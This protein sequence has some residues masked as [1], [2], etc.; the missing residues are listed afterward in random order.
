M[1]QLQR[2][3]TLARQLS[4]TVKKEEENAAGLRRD[5][6]TLKQRVVTAFRRP[7]QVPDKEIVQ[8]IGMI[9]GNLRTFVVQ[10]LD[11]F[12]RTNNAH[13]GNSSASTHGF[14][15]TF[16]NTISDLSNLPESTKEWTNTYVSLSANTNAIQPACIRPYVFVSIICKTLCEGFKAH[17]YFG[18]SAA[19]PVRGATYMAQALRPERERDTKQWFDVMWQLIDKQN[20][21][22]LPQAE[23]ALLREMVESVKH[24]FGLA[25]SIVW[26][27][28]MEEKL[29]MIFKA[30]LDLF[31]ILHRQDARYFVDMAPAN[32]W[33][34]SAAQMEEVLDVEEGPA[35]L[36]R[37][38]IDISVFPAVYKRDGKREED[39]LVTIVVKGR[40]V[41]KK[42][43][44]ANMIELDTVPRNLQESFRSHR[45][46]MSFAR[47]PSASDCTKS[48]DHD[49][50]PPPRQGRHASN[51][52]SLT[53]MRRSKVQELQDSAH[54]RSSLPRT[55]SASPT[56]TK[57]SSFVPQRT[58]R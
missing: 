38:G 33:R 43:F 17:Y 45:I 20:G 58:S 52:P 3:Q 6:R 50:T 4:A 27:E 40:V 16:A 18:T 22:I 8:R 24:D 28:T 37:R 5:L 54:A 19:S 41:S 29:S 39:E 44:L 12:C 25:L 34:F 11:S 7:E 42:Y 10:E 46:L 36:N 26:T 47:T 31:R 30:G 15:T 9:Y 53:R 14:L 32:G 51:S 21:E 13:F 1:N 48:H 23:Q 56:C 57:T 49:L 55:A 2:Q 35:A